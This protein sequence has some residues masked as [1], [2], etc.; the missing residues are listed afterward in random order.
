MYV[1]SLKRYFKSAYNGRKMS[2]KFSTLP[3]IAVCLTSFNGVPWLSEQIDSIHRQWGMALT[4]LIGVPGE[5]GYAYDSDHKQFYNEE[6]L[7]K[8]LID[9][10][11]FVDKVFYTPFKFEWFDKNI[12]QYCLYGVLIK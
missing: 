3:S 7:I 8:C 11:F 6:R 5:K 9:A 1:N 4:V 10:G 2:Q 12:S